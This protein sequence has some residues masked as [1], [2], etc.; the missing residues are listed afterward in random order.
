[1]GNFHPLSKNWWFLSLGLTCPLLVD[2]SPWSSSL[3]SMEQL[4][5]ANQGQTKK[6]VATMLGQKAMT[7]V[8]FVTVK[9]SEHVQARQPPG[10]WN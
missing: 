2:T 8:A 4:D 9:Y 3:F 10:T 5:R 6:I 1:M 7:K